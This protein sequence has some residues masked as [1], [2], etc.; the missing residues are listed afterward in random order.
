M[1]FGTIGSIGHGASG[2]LLW[3]MFGYLTDSFTSID[4]DLCS[5][6]FHYL[7]Q[8]YCPD[9]I[10]LTSSN[11]RKFYKYDN[12]HCFSKSNKLIFFY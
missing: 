2:P 10:Q 8:M 9:N 5:I 3:L 1:I 6:D 12:F 11:F 4:F 7:S